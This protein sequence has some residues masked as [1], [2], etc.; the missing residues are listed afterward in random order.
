MRKIVRLLFIL[1]ISLLVISGFCPILHTYVPDF[2][3]IDLYK[4][5]FIIGIN[6][7]YWYY[8]LMLISFVIIPGLLGRSKANRILCIVL[9]PII[10]LLGYL[11]IFLIST[12]HGSPYGIY[13]TNY[14][15]LIVLGFV[16]TTISAFVNTFSKPT[17][18]K[19]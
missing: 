17:Q 14:Y 16:F 1:G 13:P 4:E 18:L 2:S 11:L 12:S 19:N 9:L 15:Y 5:A 8:N 7:K 6:S 10:L 3:G